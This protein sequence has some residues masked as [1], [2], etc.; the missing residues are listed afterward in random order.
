L[1]LQ[2]VQI[3]SVTGF[4]MK[5]CWKLLFKSL[6]RRD[7]DLRTV[8]RVVV[9]LLAADG[10]VFPVQK[11]TL[12]DMHLHVRLGC[13]SSFSGAIAERALRIGEFD[14][15]LSRTNRAVLCLHHIR[16]TELGHI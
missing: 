15:A 6:H 13:L 5:Y 10:T 11:D 12:T 4:T 2:N 1:T 3:M 14:Y 8:W 9:T 16:Y 7:K